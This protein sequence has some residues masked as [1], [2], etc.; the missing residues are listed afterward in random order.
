MTHLRR[1]AYLVMREALFVSHLIVEMVSEGGLQEAASLGLQPIV[2]HLHPSRH[3]FLE[4][5]LGTVFQHIH[6]TI[7]QYKHIWVIR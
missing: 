4:Q 7:R 1:E 6:L 5:L 2:F 3:L